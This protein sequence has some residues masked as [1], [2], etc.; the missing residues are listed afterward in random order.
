MSLLSL[1]S[2]GGC[3]VQGAIKQTDLNEIA[4]RLWEECG[5]RHRAL[6]LVSGDLHFVTNSFTDLLCDVGEVILGVIFKTT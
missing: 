1:T 3:A 2:L 4:K 6:D 5:L